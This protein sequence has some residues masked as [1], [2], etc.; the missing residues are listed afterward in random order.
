MTHGRGRGPWKGSRGAK[1]WSTRFL[2]PFDDA[3]R[4]NVAR[5]RDDSQVSAVCDLGFEA[6]LFSGSRKSPGA[7]RCHSDSNRRSRSSSDAS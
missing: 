7:L 6:Y 3:T 1:P 2:L 4:Q 5:L